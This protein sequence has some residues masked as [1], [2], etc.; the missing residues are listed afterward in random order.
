MMY[1]EFKE[2]TGRKDITFEMY[3]GAIE[4]LYMAADVDKDG[5][6]AMVKKVP[7]EMMQILSAANKLQRKLLD[8]CS[9]AAEETK[10]ALERVRELAAELSQERDA[11]TTEMDARAAAERRH[12]NLELSVLFAPD[13]TISS[14]RAENFEFFPALLRE[15]QEE[16]IV[17]KQ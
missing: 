17:A 3:D 5:F 14:L 12:H 10:A 7:V 11:K 16:G 6:C 8:D 13:A 9:N 4:P 2:R 1:E 15:A